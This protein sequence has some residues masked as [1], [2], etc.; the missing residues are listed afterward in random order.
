[1]TTPQHASAQGSPRNQPVV[2]THYARMVDHGKGKVKAITIP[3]LQGQR[4]SFK[5]E[6]G[7][8]PI[9]PRDVEVLQAFKEN[10]EP[11][12]RGGTGRDLFE[13]KTAAEAWQ[14]AQKEHYAA[15]LAGTHGRPNAGLALMATMG[16]L[17]A[18]MTSLFPVPPL[19]GAPAF[20]A[21]PAPM[22]APPPAPEVEQTTGEK[23]LGRRRGGG[24]TAPVGG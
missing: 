8:V 5:V 23:K 2:H 11:T 3:S 1:M 12:W 9:D 13:V 21:A 10:A 14:I 15:I 16:A 17:P 20:A 24:K 19:P 4:T 7:F 22:Q 18:D 6:E